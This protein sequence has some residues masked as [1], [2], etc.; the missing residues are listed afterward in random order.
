MGAGENKCRI[1]QNDILHINFQNFTRLF[2][3]LL[4]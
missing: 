4:N 2:A 3:I 1:S